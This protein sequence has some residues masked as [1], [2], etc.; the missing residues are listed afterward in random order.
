MNIWKA[1]TGAILL[2]LGV[3][4]FWQSYGTIG[5]CNSILGRISTAV[6][7]VFGG[8]SAQA[9]YNAQLAEVGAIITALIGLVI[10]YSVF[11]E[12]RR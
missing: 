4:V 5:Q 10:L 1:I 7:S 3:V 12:K 2:V 6:A 9:C 11:T 8:G